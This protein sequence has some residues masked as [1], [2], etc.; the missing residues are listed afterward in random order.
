MI[1]AIVATI[2]NICKLNIVN[3]LNHYTADTNIVL[4]V[5]AVDIIHYKNTLTGHINRDIL[6]IPGC[7]VFC[8]AKCPNSSQQ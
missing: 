2:C 5:S 4:Y 1:V 7:S 8:L 3:H 6:L